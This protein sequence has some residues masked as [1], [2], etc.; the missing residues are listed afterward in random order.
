MEWIPEPLRKNPFFIAATT[1]AVFADRTLKAPLGAENLFLL[2]A[3][4]GAMGGVS[5]GNILAQRPTT[6]QQ[7]FIHASIFVITAVVAAV[8]YRMMLF[9]IYTP[10]LAA[11]MLECGLYAV[12]F[13]AIFGL[14]R[15]ADVFIGR[16]NG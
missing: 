12:C 14:A 10:N 9:R 4:L 15:L 5:I 1:F 8:A 7:R 16:P 6:V 13:G 3:V 11:L 2:I